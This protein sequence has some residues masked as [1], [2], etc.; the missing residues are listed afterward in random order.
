MIV[1]ASEGD[2]AGIFIYIFNNFYFVCFESKADTA[3]TL[4]PSGIPRNHSLRL[5]IASLTCC[6]T[7]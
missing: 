4:T 3:N 1:A 2:I 5:S 6:L 7:R